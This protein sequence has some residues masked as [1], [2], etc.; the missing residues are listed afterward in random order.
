MNASDYSLRMSTGARNH[1]TAIAI[2]VS[3]IPQD[4]RKHSAVKTNRER[5]NIASA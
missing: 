1:L 5:R 3:E 4:P 2:N